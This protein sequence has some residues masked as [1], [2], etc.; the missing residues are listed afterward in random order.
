MERLERMQ[1]EQQK[2]CVKMLKEE[3]NENAMSYLFVTKSM[4]CVVL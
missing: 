3:G 4:L 2:L 1:R